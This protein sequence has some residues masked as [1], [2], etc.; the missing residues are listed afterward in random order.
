MAANCHTWDG[1]DDKHL[2]DLDGVANDGL[3]AL[4]AQLALDVLLVQQAREVAVHAL[5]A[6]MKQSAGSEL[7]NGTRSKA[8]SRADAEKQRE[9]ELQ[10]IS[11]SPHR[12][13]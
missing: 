6:A 9:N 10:L 12:V 2:L 4:L 8:T 1:I 7:S 3:D 5:C 13:R 11:L